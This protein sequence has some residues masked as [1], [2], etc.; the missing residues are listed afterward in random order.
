MVDRSI[1]ALSALT[2]VACS[3]RSTP[4]SA[5]PCPLSVKT[6]SGEAANTECVHITDYSENLGEEGLEVTAWLSQWSDFERLVPEPG[7]TVH[8]EET[9]Q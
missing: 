1:R 6:S 2:R 5:T 4:D 7:Q 3:S 8:L 9:S